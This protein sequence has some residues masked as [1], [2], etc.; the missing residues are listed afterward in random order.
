M[1]LCMYYKESVMLSEL[2]YT[3]MNVKLQSFGPSGE[4]HWSCNHLDSRV[5][6]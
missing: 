3:P 5:H 6:M 4:S 2:G 1:E